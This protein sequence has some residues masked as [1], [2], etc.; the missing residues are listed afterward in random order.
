MVVI[1]M[2]KIYILVLLLILISCNNVSAGVKKC[3]PS[4][5]YKEYMKLSDEEKENYI[6]PIY[7]DEILEDTND[8]VKEPYLFANSV[9]NNI[10]TNDISATPY[11]TRYSAVEAGIVTTPKNQYGTGICWAF[12]A[13]SAVETNALMNNQ[14]THNLSEAHLVYSIIGGAY[15]D[16]NGKVNRYNHND[17]GG[18]ITYPA[19]YFFGDYGQLTESA[20]AFES[21]MTSDRKSL[22]QITSNQYV[23]GSKIL[24]VKDY[25]LANL[26]DDTSCTSSEIS[27]IKARVIN[28]G[29][30]QTTIYADSTK[31]T[32]TTD[33]YINTTGGTNLAN[34]GV[35]IVGWDDTISKSN[36]PGATRDGAWIIKNSWGPT[37]SG[38]GYFYIS[39]DDHFVCKQIA[40]YDGVS[41]KKYDNVYQSSEVVGTIKLLLDNTVYMTTRFD[42]KTADS[43]SEK[44]LR[45][46]V[47][48]GENMRYYVYLSKDN[49]L[50]SQSN[51]ILLES[52]RASQFGI[53]SVDLSNITI[54]DDFT[55]IV[56][57][58]IDSDKDTSVFTTCSDTD[59][60]STIQINTNRSYVGFGNSNWYDMGNLQLGSGT[61]RCEP[62]IYAYT[63]TIS[64]SDPFIPVNPDPPAETV[65][66]TAKS[67]SGFKVA[68][69]NIVAVVGRKE[70]FTYSTLINGLNITPSNYTVYNSKGVKV[71]SSS[72][73]IGT[74]SELKVGTSTYKIIVKGD[75]TGDGEI[76]S[77]D[78]LRV[79]QHLIGMKSVT[80][81]YYNAADTDS[82]NKIDSA[83]LL[84]I[85]QHL[86]KI[87]YIE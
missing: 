53:E 11:D 30:V 10:L 42:K 20:M 1:D 73:A 86:L 7:C 55:I 31:L 39:Y 52:K 84:K 2:K 47:P 5:E 68:S 56:K 58:V 3:T 23:V 83:D 16:A 15:S 45:V 21:Y 60:T 26:D 63:D 87:K 27:D 18:K 72:A 22:R 57:Y 51:W 13:V 76:N 35:N 38:D 54:D 69:N 80:G 65:S 61:L 41:T 37:W 49:N 85:R 50:S 77:A 29:S 78:L 28:Y 43:Q 12:S 70:K 71:T 81:V 82:N 4:E 64:N 17:S 36:F 62:N 32:N 14:G 6:E 66:V 33:Y 75:S 74:G 34:H 19:S 8:N 24:S 25:Y 79:R 46:S 44:L 59:D 9:I 40:N 48:I 67:N